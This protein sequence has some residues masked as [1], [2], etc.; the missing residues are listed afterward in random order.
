MATP[1]LFPQILAAEIDGRAHNVQYRQ[2]QFNRLQSNIVLQTDELTQAL[3]EWTGHTLEEVRAEICLALDEIR[4]HYDSLDA[5]KNLQEEYSIFHGKDFREGKRGVGIVYIVPIGHTIFFSAISAIAAALAAGNCVILELKG[6]APIIKLL[7]D[8]LI[9]ALDRDTF[10]ISEKR[11]DDAFLR[12]T[13][14]INQEESMSSRVA[15]VVDRSADIA[16]A[17][18]RL[19]SARFAFGGASPYSP[20]IVLVHEAV[21]KSFL[22][23]T[24][25]GTWK[26]CAMNAKRSF[27]SESVPELLSKTEK[28]PDAQVIVTGTGWGGNESRQSG[29]TVATREVK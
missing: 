10:A 17:A 5:E 11:P 20:D 7:Q 28:N 6:N 9:Q 29:I 15:A 14:L 18:D 12:K 23:E 19:V 4:T 27:S 16:K 1:R 26:Y 8:L 22:E 3:L 2:V 24:A 13:L 21:L 25:R